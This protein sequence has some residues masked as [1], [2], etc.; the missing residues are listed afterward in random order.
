MNYTHRASEKFAQASA[1][2]RTI[3]LLQQTM[4]ELLGHHCPSSGKC[5]NVDR[6][7][8]ALQE[9]DAQPPLKLRPEDNV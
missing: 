4:D 8:K 2:H 7:I 6:A 9:L 5:V 1:I 3:R